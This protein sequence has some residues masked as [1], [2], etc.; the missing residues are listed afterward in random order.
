M[1]RLNGSLRAK[2][3]STLGV[4]AIV[5]AACAL[6]VGYASAAQ[7]TG[8]PIKIGYIQESA[9]GPSQIDE[10]PVL[11]A[12]AKWA[13]AHG[14]VNGHPVQVI[15]DIEPNNVAVAVTDAQKLIDDGVVAIVDADANDSAWAQYPEKAGVPVFLSSDTLAFGSSDDA[16]GSPQPP[17]VT[18]DELMASAAKNGATKLAL[19]Y[20][21]EFSQCTQAV[22]FYQSVAKKY[23]VDLV[24]NA[25]VSG[26]APN[27]LAQCLAAQAAGAT[28][29]FV[30]STSATS[31]RVVANCA[32]QGYTP[33]LLAGAG[34]FQ[35]STAGTPGTNGLIATD[36]NV[37]FFD[38]SSSGIK[39]MT[40]ELNKYNPSITKSPYYDDTAVWNWAI[41][42]MLVEAAKA[43]NFTASTAITP[44]ELRDALFTLHTTTAGG[45]ITPIT[46]TKGQ[47]EA[48]RCYYNV[49][50]KK[51]KFTLPDGLKLTCV[52]AS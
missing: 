16:F 35:K 10:E 43:G 17:T 11:A 44:T 3:L 14:G 15:L 31:L 6:P 45:L 7:A 8:T 27:Y 30:A 36:G 23:G 5:G 51:N 4:L 46:M 28:S 24:Y 37:P 32:K 34:S 9:A 21:T 39:E 26:S 12:W 48:N 49:S 42:N 25:A 52:P 29:M 22:P 40:T 20:C 41:G 38:T 18:P 1:R 2:V 50:I 33:H 13:N 47:P 19:L